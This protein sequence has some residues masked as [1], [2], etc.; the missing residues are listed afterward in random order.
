MAVE[1]RDDFDGGFDQ[2][3]DFFGDDGS[4]NPPS[5]SDA[6]IKDDA[7]EIL[8]RDADF[9]DFNI[10]AGGLVGL[11]SNPG[12]LFPDAVQVTSTVSPTMNHTLGGFVAPDNCD[13]FLLARSFGA[14][15]YVLALD[16]NSGSFDLVRSDNGDPSNIA[17]GLVVPNFDPSASYILRLTAEG[18]KIRG[19]IFDTSMN[20]LLDA[21]ATDTTYADG[22]AGVG[23]A[24]NDDDELADNRTFVTGRFDDVFATNENIAPIPSLFPAERLDTRIPSAAALNV[25]EVRDIG[26]PE[27]IR[28]ALQQLLAA[29][30]AS[31]HEGTVLSFDIHD[32]D[33]GANVGSVD[34]LQQ[35]ILTDETTVDDN[36]F[37]QLVSG[38]F[39]VGEGVEGDF[40]F[41]FHT[42]D[43][44]AMRIFHEGPAAGEDLVTVPFTKVGSQGILTSAGEVA[45]PH[46]TGDSNVQA[47][48]NLAEGTYSFEMLWYEND[49]GAFAEV[50]TAMG[51]F[52]DDPTAAT[53]LLLGD[54]SGLALADG[55]GTGPSAVPGILGDYNA[56]G[57]VEQADLDLV[58]LNWGETLDDPAALGWTNDLP[59][60]L[61]DQEELD[62]VLLNW[63]NT[64]ALTSASV[65]EPGTLALVLVGS[66]VG[67]L[68]GR[69]CR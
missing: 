30:P 53:W 60:G 9:P 69:L 68:A 32:P 45:F 40:T 62:K 36:D 44:F 3:W 48:V 39:A 27:A 64:A 33:N 5:H 31:R 20:L 51:D 26:E 12:L 17:P 16:R 63:G 52:V 61:I 56:S 2:E 22:F 59:S 11:T 23:A 24:I 14:S 46:N 58:L 55:L 29:E 57:T 13:V 66:M 35:P 43:G 67:A 37:T 19:E 18:A 6:V 50:S 21:Y 38:S 4:V 10:F 41:N 8:G 54:T 15:A 65:P 34:S 25:V 7:L 49:G 42:D 1:W 47:A 28:G